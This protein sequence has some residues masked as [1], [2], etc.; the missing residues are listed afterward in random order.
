MFCMKVRL[1]SQDLM[2]SDYFLRLLKNYLDIY[3][4]I[5]GEESVGRKVKHIKE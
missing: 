5:E 1:I 2:E 4:K 3:D